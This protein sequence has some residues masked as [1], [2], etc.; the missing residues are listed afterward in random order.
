MIKKTEEELGSTQVKE[1]EE[2]GVQVSLGDNYL[3]N[4]KG[5]DVVFK[6]PSMRIDNKYLVAAKE[7]GAYI[8]SEMEEFVRYCPA[9]KYGITG[10][11][12][13]T[14]STTIIYEILKEQGYKTWVGGNIGAPLFSKIEEMT[15]DDRVVLELSSFQLMTMKEQLNVALVTNLSPNHLDM[16]KDMQEYIDAKKNVYLYQEKEDLLVINLDNDIT[17][18]MEKEATGYIRKFSLEDDRTFAYYKKD[19]LYCNNIRICSSKDIKLVGMHNVANLL[20]AFCATADDVSIES[21]RKVA[22]TMTGV[23]HRI[24]FVRE[25]NGIRYYNDAIATS[26]TRVLAGLKAFNETFGR[27]IILIAGG[28]DKNVPL[29]PLAEE[30]YDYV[31]TVILNGATSD[32][33]KKAFE[34]IMKEKNLDIKLVE[35]STLEEAVEA[36]KELG[37]DGDIV[38]LSPAC[39]AFDMFA[40]FAVKGN[41]FKEIVNSL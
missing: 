31:K 30:G 23:E 22:T 15:S 1:F 11:D 13:K 34:K 16:H 33:I 12:G 21:M 25:V 18:K 2:L 26:P 35:C 8:T 36:T 4:L 38:T 14:T 37:N 9:K 20:G 19:D 10:S 6:T 28:Y 17:N 40:N 32:K 27:K 41:R 7:D 3:D 5:F 29:E 24:E 39:A